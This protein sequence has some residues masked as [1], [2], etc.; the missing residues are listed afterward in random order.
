MRP[1]SLSQGVRGEGREV[2]LLSDGSCYAPDVSL[3]RGEGRGLSSCLVGFLW[4]KCDFVLTCFH[5]HDTGF[6]FSFLALTY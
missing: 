4:H 2:E 3:R 6:T 1:T 5:R